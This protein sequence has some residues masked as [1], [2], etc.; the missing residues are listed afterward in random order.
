M[1]TKTIVVALATLLIGSL[2][3]WACQK[4]E[5]QQV[6][7]VETENILLKAGHGGP[8]MLPFKGSG[9]WQAVEFLFPDP[10]VMEMEI[11]VEFEGTAT[12]LGRF[13]AVWTGRYTYILEN[14]VPVPGEYLSHTDVFTAANGDKL[15]GE[16]SVEEDA[17]YVPDD[18]GIGFFLTG[19]S[20]VGGT[21]RFE[22]AE[23]CYYLL[24]NATVGFPFPGGTWEIEGEISFGKLAPFRGSGTYQYADFAPDFDEMEIEIVVALE[25]RAT[26]LGRFQGIETYRFKFMIME[27]APVPT[28]YLSH[29]STYTAANGD[30]LHIEGSVEHGSGH[31]WY[32]DGTGFSLTGVHI[33]GGTGRFEN[34]VGWYDFWVTR[35]SDLGGTW[36]LEGG[37]SN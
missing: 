33:V 10:D 6:K 16:G 27:G 30:E 4:D 20:I 32:V 23:G 28:E 11:V 34:A 15:Y 21:G 8:K 2:C 9:T 26:R 13:D 12:H 25:G 17:E 37:I 22:N 24:T 18:D 36:V 29:S 19:I 14:G 31:E 5:I 7:P 35:T 3:F 1:K